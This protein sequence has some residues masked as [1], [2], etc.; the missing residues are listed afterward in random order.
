MTTTPKKKTLIMKIKSLTYCMVIG[1]AL[2]AAAAVS[3]EEARQLGTTLTPF[4]AIKAG[5][6][7]GTIHPTPVELANFRPVLNPA[8]APGWTPS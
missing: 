3:D 5:N 6:A 1:L 4:G 2:P 8:A 7:S